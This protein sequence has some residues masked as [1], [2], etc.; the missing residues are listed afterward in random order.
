M[1]ILLGL[2]SVN[3]SNISA[4]RRDEPTIRI[5]L[6]WIHIPVRSRC[7]ILGPAHRTG[8]I[9]GSFHLHPRS[10]LFSWYMVSFCHS[11]NISYDLHPRNAY[12]T[13]NQFLQNVRLCR[14]FLCSH[15][16]HFRFRSVQSE[17]TECS[18]HRSNSRY[19]SFIL[20]E[21]VAE[22]IVAVQEAGAHHLCIILTG[23]GAA[24]AIGLAQAGADIC[25]V[26]VS[27][28]I[29]LIL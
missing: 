24:C 11:L 7:L 17:R 28:S 29:H 15:S 5:I 14:S 1:M 2:V 20:V 10:R 9:T 3:L 6:G 19:V 13:L 26:Q 23:I 25:L 27:L 21:D 16:Q 8:L 22:G 12:T 18:Y 4:I